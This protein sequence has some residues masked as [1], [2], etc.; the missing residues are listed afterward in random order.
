[1]RV[2]MAATV[3]LL[4]AAAGFAVWRGPSAMAQP[5]VIRLGISPWP[6]DELVW[7]AH[8]RGYFAAEGIDLRLVNFASTSDSRLAY[9]R[10]QIDGMSASMV[11]FLHAR[12]RP[13]RDARIV[14]FQDWS[15]G[16][17]VVLARPDIASLA[18]LK[19]RKV[20]VE[21]GTLTAFV[22]ARALADVGLGIS[23]VTLV[24]LGLAS[25]SEAFRRGE[26]DAV[27]AYPPF[28]FDLQA[29]GAAHALFTSATTPEEILDFLVIDG[30]VLAANPRLRAG[31]ARAWQRVLDDLAREPQAVAAETAPREGVTPAEFLAALGGI[32]LVSRA[33]Q[34]GLLRADGPFRPAFARC[35]ATLRQIGELDSTAVLDDCVSGQPLD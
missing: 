31:M 25:S 9:E 7:L 3:V 17:D 1:M 35:I 34:D 13:G 10:G 28:S 6:P 29:D 26:V 24:P 19:G 27:V 20:A 33:E 8:R 11:E 12:A 15:A 14:L 21:P 2:F 22:L 23:D 5:A 30:A 32:H 18:G 16:A 4:I